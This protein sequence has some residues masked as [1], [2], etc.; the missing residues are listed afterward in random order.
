MSN[1]KNYPEN[2]PMALEFPIWVI[3]SDFDG[4]RAF[5]RSDGQILNFSSY[6]WQKCILPEVP[7]TVHIVSVTVEKKYIVNVAARKLFDAKKF[8]AG[9]SEQG[10]EVVAG[11]V[12]THIN[13]PQIQK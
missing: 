11:L 1:W 4:P 7:V 8:V 2:P 3:R 5:Y 13:Q 6:Q 12:E 10:L 9:L